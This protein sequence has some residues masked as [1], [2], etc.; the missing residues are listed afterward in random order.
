LSKGVL[1]KIRDGLVEVNSRPYSVSELY[2]SGLLKGE[3]VVNKSSG[4]W[5]EIVVE[6][7]STLAYEYPGILV[8]GGW[9]S[10]GGVRVDVVEKRKSFAVRYASTQR[11]V[12]EVKLV[13]EG[14]ELRVV[15]AFT[16]RRITLQCEGSIEV[17]EEPFRLVLRARARK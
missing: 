2:V 11:E 15:A 12:S 7:S 17:S 14:A 5:G 16:P 3:V 9:S 10:S 6:S 13:F 8:I 4:I 1:L